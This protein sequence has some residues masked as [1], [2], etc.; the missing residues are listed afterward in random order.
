MSAAFMTIQGYVCQLLLFFFAYQVKTRTINAVDCDRFFHTITWNFNDSDVRKLKMELHHPF[1]SS[2]IGVVPNTTYTVKIEIPNFEESSQ[3]FVTSLPSGIFT[4]NLNTSVPCDESNSSLLTNI[5]EK[6]VMFTW[7]SPAERIIND[8]LDFMVV[9]AEKSSHLVVATASTSWIK[10]CFYKVTANYGKLNSEDFRETGNRCT[11]SNILLQSQSKSTIVL[12]FQEIHLSDH[13]S[14][15]IDTESQGT[16]KY[17]TPKNI[18]LPHRRFI[19]H[20]PYLMIRINNCEEGCSFSAIFNNQFIYCNRTYENSKGV[21]TSPDYPGYYI[22]NQYCSDR[23]VTPSNSKIVL[24]IEE[25]YF[26]NLN[27]CDKDYVQISPVYR[28][29]QMTICHNVNRIN[30]LS[31]SNILNINYHVTTTVMRYRF[32]YKQMSPCI[33]TT[34]SNSTGDVCTSGYYVDRNC[35]YTFHVPLGYELEVQFTR[36]VTSSSH[37]SKFC[38]QDYVILKSSNSVLATLCGNW[39]GSDEYPSY[40]SVGNHFELIMSIQTPLYADYLGGICIHYRAVIVNA[41]YTSCEYGWISGERY[42]Y[43]LSDK[44][45]SWIEADLWCQERDGHLA[46][47]TGEDISRLIE[48]IIKSSVLYGSVH[49]FWIGANDMTYENYY[50]WAD[51]QQFIYSNWFPGWKN[52]ENYNAQPSDDG[53]SQQDCVELRDE[54]PYPNKGSGITDRFYWNDRDCNALNYFICQKPKP[55]VVIVP[56]PVPDCNRTIVLS[57]LHPRDVI[58]SPGYD[59][60]YPADIKCHYEITCAQGQS[61]D[62]H[63]T[64]FHLE[65]HVNCNNADSCICQYDFLQLEDGDDF[66]RR[67]CGDWRRRIK[68]LRH[69]SITN[70]VRLIFVA[71]FSHSYTGFRIEVFLFSKKTGNTLCENKLFHPFDNHC[72]LIASFPEVSWSTAYRICAESQTYLTT[73]EGLEEEKFL[74][75]LI[76]STESYTSG[77]IYWLGAKWQSSDKAW[78]WVDG[79]FIVSTDDRIINRPEMYT[80]TSLCLAVQWRGQNNVS[81]LFWTAKDCNNAGRYICKKPA[82]VLPEN[83]NQTLTALSGTLTSFNYPSNYVNDLHYVV[84]IKG[85][86]Q[87]RIWFRFQHVDIEWQEQCLY[88]YVALQNSPNGPETRVCGQEDDRLDRYDFFSDKNTLYVTFHS[89]YSLTSNGFVAT[90]EVID[91]SSC[92]DRYI[93]VS[94][95]GILTSIGYPGP[96]LP[97]MDCLTTLITSTEDLL[98]LSFVSFDVG[99]SGN[100]T[101]DYLRIN[102]DNTENYFMTMCGNESNY[103]SGY[104][105]LSYDNVLRLNFHS[106]KGSR[107]GYTGYNVTYQVLKRDSSVQSILT[108]PIDSEGII[109]SLNYPLPSPIGINYTQRIV[110]P[111]GYNIQLKLLSNQTLVGDCSRGEVR[112][113]DAYTENV[114]SVS[115]CQAENKNGKVNFLSTLNSMF[116]LSST[117]PQFHA[118]FY[119]LKFKTFIDTQFVSKTLFFPSSYVDACI[120]NPCQHEGICVTNEDFTSY[121]NCQGQFTGLFCHIQWCDLQPCGEHGYCNLTES[122]YICECEPKFTGEHCTEPV[123]P[124]NP[125]PCQNGECLIQTNGSFVCHCRV[126][127]EG[128]FCE[129]HVF[130]IPYKPLSKRML[131]EPFWLGLIT[132]SV[133]LLVILCIYCIKR[134]FADKIEKFLAEEIERSKNHSSP[135]TTRYSLSSNQPCSTPANLSPQTCPKSILNRIRKHSIRST[136]GGSN[137]PTDRDMGCTFSFDEILKRT[138][139]QTKKPI[140]TNTSTPSNDSDKKSDEK[141]RILASLV[142]SSPSQRRLSLDEFFRLSERKI[143]MSNRKVFSQDG[144]SPTEGNTAETT[145]IGCLSPRISHYSA[146]SFSDFRSVKEHSF[147]QNSSSDSLSGEAKTSEVQVEVSPQASDSKE[148]DD[149]TSKTNSPIVQQ[150]PEI[151]ITSEDPDC[152]ETVNAENNCENPADLNEDTNNC[153]NSTSSALSHKSVFLEVPSAE[154]QGIP[155]KQTTTTQTTLTK[156]PCVVSPKVRKSDIPR[157]YSV[158]L[159]TPKIL[160][161]ANMSSCDSD[162]TSPPRTPNPIKPMAYLSPLAVICS[163]ADRTIS[164]SN[165]S[166]SGY[167][168]LSSPGLS[169]CNSSSPLSDELDIQQNLGTKSR[170]NTSPQKAGSHLLS[171]SYLTVKSDKA[172]QFPPT[173][174][175]PCLEI[176]QQPGYMKRRGSM[177]GSWYSSK[178][179]HGQ[180]KTR[181]RSPY[182]QPISRQNSV[183]DEGIGMES[184]DQGTSDNETKCVKTDNFSDEESDNKINEKSEDK[185]KTT[186]E[187]SEMPSSGEKII[188]D[189]KYPVNNSARRQSFSDSDETNNHENSKAKVQSRKKSPSKQ[190]NN[191]QN[192]PSQSDASKDPK[193]KERDPTLAE[194]LIQVFAD[195]PNKQKTT[196]T[197]KQNSCPAFPLSTKRWIPLPTQRSYPITYRKTE[198]LQS[199]DSSGSSAP[200]DTEDLFGVASDDHHPVLRRQG[201]LSED[202]GDSEES[203]GDTTVLLRKTPNVSLM[204]NVSKLSDDS[205][206]SPR[207][208]VS[209]SDSSSTPSLP[210][211]LDSTSLTEHLVTEEIPKN[212]H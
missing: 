110:A 129:K 200:S 115:L 209:L 7:K 44:P 74:Y 137:S 68:L 122:S 93:N 166:T 203:S 75:S 31:S 35:K 16:G 133:V 211:M 118:P 195:N 176:F 113:E 116:I 55:G 158:D 174:V 82:I 105:I 84:T 199:V 32:S 138:A 111:I 71:D 189:L 27:N 72:Y 94:D 13:S 185:R 88:D 41:N 153:N 202:D 39:T 61:I 34:I 108:L 20:G 25:L 177:S 26:R 179:A 165:L 181:F 11:E 145:F 198:R 70:S 4:V 80:G 42:C 78:Q 126:W 172:F 178:D 183:E 194:T 17:F 51:K 53:L 204:K 15:A 156:S 212:L 206:S 141:S 87:S 97:D 50:N 151:S 109:T 143:Q 101:T 175:Y 57:S 3:V 140:N 1:L 127:Y 157:K 77:A 91:I 163:S 210:E 180:I 124:C 89:D 90:W 168:S 112:L 60:I 131:E 139:Q 56:I 81:G 147:E 148:A 22:P 24:T 2:H 8:T 208:T 188:S 33:N 142:T 182:H 92:D 102:L 23:I 120:P 119:I 59:N 201:A 99:K 205:T 107:F 64:D 167:S 170:E 29:G 73:I 12:Q 197:L 6:Y 47:V 132:V 169:R 19:S 69:V 49:S 18:D 146:P 144:G 45:L 37:K 161:T 191:S 10:G 152:L 58:M 114:T 95:F 121:C 62:L 193:D 123:A 154:N 28:T 103:P 43:R 48:E 96:Y 76:K 159:P 162:E 128:P 130:Q 117:T 86:E 173:H 66:K 54:F 46:S 125:N 190:Q 160:I 134:K 196:K 149:Q 9:Y 36:I 79:K 164:E 83:L 207:I 21:I 186:A 98:L 171:P 192:P 14:I 150:V 136:R 184:C 135:P 100:C 40:R 38:D 187:P 52:R 30:Y 65:N 5:I 63:F 85:P 104:A 67:Y 155:I 106:D